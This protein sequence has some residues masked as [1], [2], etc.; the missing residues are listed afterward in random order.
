MVFFPYEI[1]NMLIFILPTLFNVWQK[2]LAAFLS[3]WI[4]RANLCWA[5]AY[6]WKIVLAVFDNPSMIFLEDDE[7]V[8]HISWQSYILS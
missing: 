1:G 6:R 7:D 5:Q 2:I 8:L 4:L 3:A